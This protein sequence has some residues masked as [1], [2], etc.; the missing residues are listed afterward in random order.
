MSGDNFWGRQGNKLILA[1]ALALVSLQPAG[2]ADMPIRK[3][4]IADPWNWSGVYVGVNVGYKPGPV[5]HRLRHLQQYDR[6][7]ALQQQQ[8]VRHARRNRRRPDRRELA[9]RILCRR[10]RSRHSGLRPEGLHVLHLPGRRLQQHHRGAGGT[11]L[12][13]PPFKLVEQG[14]PFHFETGRAVLER[15][16]AMA[17]GDEIEQPPPLAAP[18]G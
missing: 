15:V 11:S 16:R 13:A 6:R 1:G 17:L 9:V 12:V 3:A 8:Y 2:A 4:P 14:V 10:L 7:D 5:E 18:T